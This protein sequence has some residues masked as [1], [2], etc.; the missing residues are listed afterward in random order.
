MTKRPTIAVAVHDGFYGCG[1][2]AGYANFGF[3]ETLVRLL[4]TGVGLAILPVY[5]DASSP[6]YHPA[7]H[8]RARALVAS[9]D[10]AVYPV[11]N[12]TNGL[13]RWGTWTNFEHL[14]QDTAARI[15]TTV[16]PGSDPLLTIAFDAPFLGLA[17]LLPRDTLAN[18][19]LVPRS[20]AR[21]HA[22][23]DTARIGW[24]RSGL[25]AGLADG[26]LVG[27]ISSFMGRHLRDE[28][29]VPR[30]SLITLQDGLTPA[31]W[32]RL[33]ATP[34]RASDLPPAT[35]F[36]L[37][38]GRAEPYKGFDDLLDAYAALRA[39]T[40]HLP[41]LVL[42]ATAET[43]ASSYQQHLARRVAQL[44]IDATVLTEFT[45][46]VPGLL[47]H[48]GL[49]GVVVPSRVEPFGR[50][51]MEAFAAGAVPVITTTAQGL[52][53]QVIDGGTGFHCPPGTPSALATALATALDLDHDQRF[54]FR[55]RARQQALRHY[56]HPAAV[57]EF[58]TR[59]APW[60]PLP[61]P[62]DQLRC[63]SSTAPSVTTG[64]SVSAVPPVK[65][66]IGL[67]ARHWTTVEPERHVLIIAHHVTSLVRLMDVLPVFD[68]DPR[69]QVVFTWNGSDPFRHGLDQYLTDLGVVVIPWSQAIETEFDL[70][71]AANHG[72]LTEITAPLVIL[73]HGVG[74]TKNSPGNRKPETGNR[75]PETGNRKPET[76]NRKP[77]CVRPFSGM[78]ALQ[79]TAGRGFAGTRA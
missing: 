74:Y 30:E 37:A 11:H 73:P 16:Q 21:I 36:V 63:L 46:D 34:H 22:P 59:T 55:Q 13:D 71:I 31:D 53:G 1:T 33:S 62:D 24:E 4:P 51:P 12:G 20:T 15:M 35:E 7:W 41:H 47:R 65:V 23:W 32:E 14:A 60:L 68:S 44:D 5:L 6:E 17:K 2:G 69:V 77:F 3:L 28:Y 25:H 43:G 58:L 54:A 64:S 70:A 48:P 75:K 10:A 72:G 76:G 61:R 27:A 67:Q 79:R 18:L 56:D 19:V 78:A 8:A 49:R 39:R 29:D 52:A 42:A 66:P 45:S 40:D 57:R 9:A 50:I 26:T 38:M